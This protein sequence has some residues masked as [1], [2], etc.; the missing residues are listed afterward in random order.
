MKISLVEFLN[1]DKKFYTQNT[2]TIKLEGDGT[3]T[4]PLKAHYLG[5]GGP[6]TSY[7]FISPLLKDA[8]NNV[9]IQQATTSQGG[10]LSASDFIAFSNK[11]DAL[12]FPLAVNLGGTGLNMIGSP[13]QVLRVNSLGT[14][15]EFATLPIPET[16]NLIAGTN[17]TIT[18]TYPNL[19]ISSTGGSGGTIWQLNGSVAYYNNNVSVGND[20]SQF[21][22]TFSVFRSDHDFNP[23]AEFVNEFSGNDYVASILLGTGG[24]NYT[25]FDFFSNSHATKP[26]FFEVNRNGVVLFGVNGSGEFYITAYNGAGNSIIG[27]DTQGK[28]I[29]TLVD[30]NTQITNK[31]TIPAQVNL[32]QGTGITITGTYPNLTISATGAGSGENPLTFSAPLTRTGDVIS[33]PAANGATN[34]YLSSTDW[35]TFNNKLSSVANVG[36]G[37]AVYK[38]TVANVANFKTFTGTSGKIIVQ[39]SG[40]DEINIDI[41]PTFVGG[42]GASNVVA[43][44]L[45]GV[46]GMVGT[47][48][49]NTIYILEDMGRNPFFKYDPLDTTSP[50]DGG[51]IVVTNDGYRLKRIVVG[52]FVTSDMYQL[53]GGNTT[54]YTNT[55]INNFI[56]GAIRIGKKAKFVAGVHLFPID[57]Q[58]TNGAYDDLYI[59]GEGKDVTIITNS[60]TS[61]PA[62]STPK[63]VD[64][65]EKMPITDGF[66]Q[67]DETDRQIR[68]VGGVPTGTYHRVHPDYAA[69]NGAEINDY[70]KVVAG[71]PSIA[72]L[73]EVKLAGY[74]TEL[75]VD[76]ADPGYDG[77]YVVAGGTG[78][79]GGGYGHYELNQSVFNTN[80]EKVPYLIGTMLK[81]VGGVWSRLDF[82]HGFVTGGHIQLQDI[83]FRDCAFYPYTPKS[84]P[85]DFHQA[86]I[87]GR[88]HIIKNCSFHNVSRVN[89][90]D[91]W[92]LNLS[93]SG[94]WTDYGGL[95]PGRYNHFLQ[96]GHKNYDHTIIEDCDFS[97]IHTSIMWEISPT[98]TLKIRNCNIR[99][100]FTNIEC[101]LY[102]PYGT[103]EDG[104]TNE[105]QN[106]LFENLFFEKVRKYDPKTNG[107]HLLRSLGNATYNNIRI[108]SGS[109]ICFYAGGSN[110]NFTNCVVDLFMEDTPTAS[111]DEWAI[112]EV[113]HVKGFNFNDPN[114]VDLITNCTVNAAWC[115]PIDQ[116]GRDSDLIVTNSY[117][118]HAGYYET[119]TTQTIRLDQRYIYWISD[120][121]TFQ[122]LATIAEDGYDTVIYDEANITGRNQYVYWDKRRMIWRRWTK[123]PMTNQ[124]VL[125]RTTDSSIYHPKSV[126]FNGCILKGYALLKANTSSYDRIVVNG[127]ELHTASDMIHARNGMYLNRLYLNDV[128]WYRKLGATPVSHSPEIKYFYLNNVT[129]PTNPLN[130][131]LQIRFTEECEVNGLRL[132][133]DNYYDTSTDVTP[134][135]MPVNCVQFMGTGS[136]PSLKITNSELDGKFGRYT[137]IDITGISN[138]SITNTKFKLIQPYATGSLMNTRRFCIA[139]TGDQTIN[140]LI[141]ENIEVEADAVNTR[142][143]FLHLNTGVATIN[144]LK[145]SNLNTYVGSDINKIIYNNAGSFSFGSVEYGRANDVIQDSDFLS[146]LTG[147][148][149]TPNT[150]RFTLNNINGTYVIPQGVL[151][152]NIIVKALNAD[153]PSLNLGTTSGGGELFTG[154]VLQANPL[155]LA[156]NIFA[157]T[158]TTL[159]FNGITSSA[160]TVEVTIYKR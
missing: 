148:I 11:Q 71:V 89:G 38:N 4:R 74:V 158:A 78:P 153:L 132:I 33:I 84:G 129:I 88:N 155:K 54:P 150:T 159:Y 160:V 144:N 75:D 147:T 90:Q 123:G 105:P 85:T 151:I 133:P 152:D 136:S 15:L 1:L 48:D 27:V 138:I 94:G 51:L 86:N 146:S 117:L 124:G 119:V 35:T 26:S 5:G 17:I 122:S 91:R 143:L 13:L 22:S 28:I 39:A 59:Y 31:P 6:G 79:T 77:I 72:T 137:P 98:R 37:V 62:L 139:F 110:N 34:G 61:T 157:D 29:K 40:A 111:I 82:T 130:A 104:Y 19:T 118:A 2:S 44:S 120:F 140:T 96:Q 83:T 135:G 36:S 9:S 14:A 156:T 76:G 63:R 131:I 67:V 65:K 18:G 116:K 68:K 70:I 7:N 80:G 45:S 97:Y 126:I 56:N 108:K 106:V 87:P 103:G 58:S 99:E 21:N 8:D 81:R 145:I 52:E 42:G 23:L 92:G 149:T 73:E 107:Y 125:D 30:Y 141:L 121:A 12:S 112:P 57:F 60:I 66:L 64:L 100:C 49:V 142:A 109:G 53:N 43:T 47:P 16:V 25:S 46:R 134:N 50:D 128:V 114:G 95:V 93:G 69:V 20:S 55:Q 41:D 154:T 32:I 113:F 101:F 3:K 127:G 24:G 115:T 10:Y 102:N